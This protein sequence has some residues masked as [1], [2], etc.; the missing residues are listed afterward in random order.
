VLSA[1]RLAA[2]LGLL[3]GAVVVMTGAGPAAAEDPPCHWEG[4]EYIC[5]VGT[6]GNPGNPG[7]PGSPGGSKPCTY[8]GVEYPCSVPGMGYFNPND[9]CYYRL[10]S[11]QPALDDP[12]WGDWDATPGVG[13]FW[14]VH[15]V[16]VGGPGD[17]LMWR[18]TPPPGAPGGITPAELA[19]QA[20]ARMKLAGAAIGRVPN[21]GGRGLVGMPVWLWTDV[22]PTTWGPIEI[23]AAVPGLS[24]T[25]KAQATKIVW[26]MGDENSVTCTTPGT[27]WTPALGV[28]PS[29]DCGYMYSTPSR[30]RPGGQY[31]I[32]ATTSWSIHWWVNGGGAT[33][34]ENTTRTSTTTII[35]DELQVVTS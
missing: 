29:P 28:G 8:Q 24:V 35:I 1:R 11:P 2:V 12:I 10:V 26:A 14:Y 3:L 19:A 17:T 21:V 16:A 6:P 15:C 34:D 27:K 25:A 5:D 4:S 22:T 18:A 33:G 13:S 31:T 9:G 7:N 23:T 30:N 32:T 20:I